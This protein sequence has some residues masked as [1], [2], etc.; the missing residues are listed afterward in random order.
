MTF[1][2]RSRAADALNVAPEATAAEACAAFLTSLPSAGFLPSQQ[3][4]A[5]VNALAGLNLP[6]DADASPTVREEVAEF[7]AQYWT[8]KPSERLATW[9]ALTSRRP[10][11]AT[12]ERLL[13]LQSGLELSAAPVADPQQEEL[14]SLARELYLLPPRECAIRRNEWLLA[15][16]DNHRRLIGVA[17]A[18]R[19][20][21]PAAA[22]LDPV[23]F[24][25]LT[26]AFQC[27]LFAEAAAAETLPVRS[28]GAPNPIT[29]ASPALARV[30]REY[31]RPPERKSGFQL[32]WVALV[33]LG[34]LAKFFIAVLNGN[35]ARTTTP[36]YHAPEPPKVWQADLPVTPN[37][38]NSLQ[39]FNDLRIISTASG[40]YVTQYTV[41]PER[42]QEFKDYAAFEI[43]APGVGATIK[44]PPFGYRNWINLGRPNSGQILDGHK[45]AYPTNR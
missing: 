28:Y 25:R 3:A 14:L 34:I 33:G 6:V 40:G 45:L 43:V 2:V 37:R 9:M 20:A 19:D 27:R 32:G 8:L 44:E 24:E 31:S 4:V 7:I 5:A 36:S 17:T 23:L 41:S 39:E 11:D 35:H 13:E 10:D 1:G 18:V 29:D 21:F 38:I 42:V 16:A 30:A 26:S 15:N 12:A 22:A